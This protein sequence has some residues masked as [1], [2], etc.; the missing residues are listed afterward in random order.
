MELNNGQMILCNELE[1]WYRNKTKP[2]F[3]YSGAAGTGKTTVMREFVENRIGLSQL[4]YV[5]AALVGKAVLV[6]LQ[7]GLP[8]KTIHSLIFDV[9][10]DTI[11]DEKNGQRYVMQF[12]LKEALDSALKLLVID[13]A[14]MVNDDMIQKILSF[15]VPTVF[16][17]DMNQL[18]PIFGSSSVMLNPDFMLNELMRQSENDPIVWIANQ[19]LLGF[20]IPYGYY[21]NCRMMD[22]IELGENLLRDY[23]VILCATNR[24]R[25]LLCQYIRN[26]IL[27][28][29]N[30]SLPNINEKMICRQNEW[31]RMIDQYSLTNGTIGY[32]R[33]ID[34]PSRRKNMKKI[35]IEFEPEYLPGRK[36]RNVPLDLKYL[37]LNYKDRKDYGFSSAIKFEYGYTLTT[38][39]SQGSEYERVLFID[40]PAFD[41]ETRCKLRYTAATRAKQKLDVVDF[42]A[43]KYNTQLNKFKRI[44]NFE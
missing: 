10:W 11:N 31:E 25:E 17:G 19:M 12:I 38:H 4:E 41:Y 8:A 32:I 30:T 15:G 37:R 43:I 24:T 9:G 26:E 28:I 39:L 16:S 14:P 29:Q 2:Y 23:D 20:R 40:E 7:K 21:D 3:A 33:W 22:E 5:C 42:N 27:C 34:V 44:I 13:E 1:Y 36:W 6:M 18:P 35:H